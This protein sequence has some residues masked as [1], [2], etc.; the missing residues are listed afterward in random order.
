MLRRL[1]DWTMSFSANKHAMWTLFAIAFIESSVFPLPPDILLV[2][3][4]LAS[5]EKAWKI[6][7]VCTIASVLGGLAG[8]GIGYFLFESLG[9]PLLA[10]YGKAAKFAE[11]QTL[12]QQWGAW[13]VGMAGVTPFPYKVITIASGVAKLDLGT[14]VL[15]SVLSRGVRF[16]LEAF[17]LWYFGEPIRAF[18]EKYLGVLATVGFIILLGGFVALK[19][20]F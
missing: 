6:A 7:G 1:Y 12:Y 11:F 5:R 14:F 8:Y 18:I 20:V 19:Y 16:F 4:I 15:A 13:V 3:M 2:P 17:L 9:Q 10:F